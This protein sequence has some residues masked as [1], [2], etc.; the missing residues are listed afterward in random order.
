MTKSSYPYPKDEFD[1]VPADAPTGVHRVPRSMWSRVLPFV[2]VAVVL[3]VVAYG[4]GT[5]GT[6]LLGG[7]ESDTP[8][9]ASTVEPSAT[10]TSGSTATDDA[11]ESP[12]ATSSP[13]DDADVDRTLAVRVLNGAGI[14]GLAKQGATKLQQDGF[15][16]VTAAD[17]TGAKLSTS[18]VYYQGDDAKATAKR[19]ASVL[20]IETVTPVSSLRAPVSVVLV[21]PLS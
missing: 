11:S 8:P 19:V 9:A 13:D 16:S 20:G 5:L 17:Y 4:A 15:T 14:T 6:R 10:K 21:T 12:T 7:G 3:A 18:V 2:L 1:D